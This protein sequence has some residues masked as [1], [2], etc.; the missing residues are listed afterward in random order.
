MEKT[1]VSLLSSGS[2]VGRKIGFNPIENVTPT[3]IAATAGSKQ[4]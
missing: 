1:L 4:K 2:P 3:A